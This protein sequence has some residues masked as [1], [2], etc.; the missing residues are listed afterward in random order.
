[1]GY[2]PWGREE[3]DTTERLTT[4]TL[5]KNQKRSPVP[6]ANSLNLLP[7]PGSHPAEVSPKGPISVTAPG[8]SQASMELPTQPWV[9]VEN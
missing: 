1:M 8:A 2:S 7:V 6:V 3:A 9:A 4:H 5:Q